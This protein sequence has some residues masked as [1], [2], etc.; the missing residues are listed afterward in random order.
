[1]LPEQRR[2]IVRA[3]AKLD[4]LEYSDW[5]RVGCALKS[6]GANDALDLW[7]AWCKSSRKYRPGECADRW[8]GISENRVSLG[9]IYPLAN[10]DARAGRGMSTMADC[11][12]EQLS[13]K[14]PEYR[15]LSGYGVEQA[16][17]VEWLVKGL[18]PSQGL[19]AIYG[20]SGSGKTFLAIN[21]ALAIAGDEEWF[22]HRV[23]KNVPTVYSPS[24]WAGG[25]KQCLLA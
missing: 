24:E 2:N 15:L 23:V 17:G 8:D 7:T 3:L 5:F 13:V 20:A 19:A 9:T 6:T 10:G 22:G 1:L 11:E 4:D 14:L 12:R 18:L 16:P 21:I 25:I